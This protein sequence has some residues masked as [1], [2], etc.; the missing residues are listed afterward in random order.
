MIL[1]FSAMLLGMFALGGAFLAML[2]WALGQGQ[3]EEAEAACF[4]ALDLDA[5]PAPKARTQLP[6]NTTAIHQP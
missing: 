4:S 6:A 1:S 5:A 2:L 3:F